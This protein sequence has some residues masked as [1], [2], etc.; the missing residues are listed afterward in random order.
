MSAPHTPG[1]WHLLPRSGLN[2]KPG[3]QRGTEG[4]FLVYGSSAEREEA[5]A[6]LIA[7]A[8]ALLKSLRWAMAFVPAPTVGSPSVSAIHDEFAR[9]HAAALAAIAAAEGRS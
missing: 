5:D 6:R 7:Q 4:G 2:D 8:P 3:V 1:P 9:N